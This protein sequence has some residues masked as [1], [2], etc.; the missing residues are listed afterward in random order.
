M[1]FKRGTVSYAGSQFATHA[2]AYNTR[3]THLMFA[4]ED[5]SA[6]LGKSP[7]ETPFGRVAEHSLEIM[8]KIYTGYGERFPKHGHIMYREIN[9]KG[10]SF[11]RETFPEIDFINSCKV[12]SVESKGKAKF[13]DDL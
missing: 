5:L 6:D 13:Y 10:N 9:E 8:D 7:W 2:D 12:T 4:L 3:T 1:S 11:V